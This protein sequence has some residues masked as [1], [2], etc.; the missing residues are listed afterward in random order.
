MEVTVKGR[1][2]SVTEA[3]ERYAFEKVERV[4]KFFVDE[5]SVSRAEVE[6]ILERDTSI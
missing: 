2:M 1:N 5:H 4:R 6:L 3:L